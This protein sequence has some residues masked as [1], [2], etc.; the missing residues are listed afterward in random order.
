LKFSLDN[1][2]LETIKGS[3]NYIN[4]LYFFWSITISQYFLMHTIHIQENY[5]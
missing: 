2:N 3:Y 5:F 1:F 4:I